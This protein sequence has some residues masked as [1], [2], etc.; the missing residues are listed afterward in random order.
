MNQIGFNGINQS[1]FNKFKNLTHLTINDS[2]QTNNHAIHNISGL[3][4]NLKYL[5]IYNFPLTNKH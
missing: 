2:V 4:F 1:F 3:P 5:A